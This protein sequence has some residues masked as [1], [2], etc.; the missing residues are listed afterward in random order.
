MD[1]DAREAIGT[2]LAAIG[3]ILE[4]DGVCSTYELAETLGGVAMMT[5]EAGEQFQWR[6]AYIGSWA[7]MVNAAADGRQRVN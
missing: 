7:M 2:V 6:A 4:R 3:G 5:A 1:D